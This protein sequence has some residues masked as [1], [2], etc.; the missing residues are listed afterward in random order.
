[1]SPAGWEVGRGA[2]GGREKF[3][4]SLQF[5]LHREVG[6]STGKRLQEGGRSEDFWRAISGL[7]LRFIEFKI[8]TGYSDGGVPCMD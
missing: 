8:C 4:N 6:L 7:N 5:L 3:K 2:Q 1:M